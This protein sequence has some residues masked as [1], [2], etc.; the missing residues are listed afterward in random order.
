MNKI[1]PQVFDSQNANLHFN[2]HV[3]FVF[4]IFNPKHLVLFRILKTAH[5]L[6]VRDIHEYVESVNSWSL[7]TTARLRKLRILDPEFGGGFIVANLYGD[8]RAR[9]VLLILFWVPLGQP[10]VAWTTC[11][12]RI[13]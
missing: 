9:L 2:F 7:R 8:F 5:H 13:R 1:R 3:A 4:R 11:G 6:P 10:P 12:N